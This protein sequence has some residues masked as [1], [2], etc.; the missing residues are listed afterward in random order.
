MPPR[1]VNAEELLAA[2]I[3]GGKHPEH[4]AAY[5]RYRATQTTSVLE[6]PDPRAAA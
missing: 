3:T 5:E 1:V 4:R 2:T 6:N